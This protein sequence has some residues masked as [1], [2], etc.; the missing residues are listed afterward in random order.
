MKAAP[1]EVVS[2]MYFFAFSPPDT[3]TAFRPAGSDTSKKRG[4]VATPASVRRQAGTSAAANRFMDFDSHRPVAERP[5][6]GVAA[7]RRA[8]A[9]ELSASETRHIRV[10]RRR[11]GLDYDR[12]ASSCNE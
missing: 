9:V 4:S 5:S 2:I 10:E 11:G 8:P 1:P 12:P 7:K 6:V 3:I